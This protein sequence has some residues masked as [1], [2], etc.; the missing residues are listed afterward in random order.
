[1]GG[2]LAG[3][4]SQFM[5]SRSRERLWREINEDT[6]FDFW[7]LHIYVWACSHTH[8]TD[9]H[10]HTLYRHAHTLFRHA[11]PH[12]A[13]MHT[14]TVQVCTHTHRAGIHT[15]TLYRH[16]HTHCTGMHIH[17]EQ[18]FTYTHCAG[19]HTHTLYRHAHTYCTG[20]CTHTHTVQACT[21]ILYRHEYMYTHPKILNY[22]KTVVRPEVSEALESNMM[23]SVPRNWLEGRESRQLE[24][25]QGSK[26]LSL[27][28]PSWILNFNHE[29][30]FHR[31]ILYF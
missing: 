13:G 9:M 4:P 28:T 5:S 11:H 22:N 17:T 14:H 23:S 29:D 2:F 25:V 20:M 24:F 26:Y 3:Q 8:C 1:M 7:P 31:K 10:T 12:C 15:H 27:F 21:H 18:V 19:M 30:I 6:W 16:A